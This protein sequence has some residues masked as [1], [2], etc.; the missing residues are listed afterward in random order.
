MIYSGMFLGGPRAGQWVN[1][2]YATYECLESPAMHAGRFAPNAARDPFM[3]PLNLT[4]HRYLWQPLKL[5][6]AEEVG[7]F[8][9]ESLLK[10]GPAG[11]LH[12]LLKGYGP[13]WV[14]NEV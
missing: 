6:A 1:C 14:R 13:A 5:L 9:H 10:E 4:V 11:W 12:E 8:V 3:A 7:L 2:E